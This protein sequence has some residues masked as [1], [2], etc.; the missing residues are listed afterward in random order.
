MWFKKF[1]D[2]AISLPVGHQYR[3]LQDFC[4]E[5]WNRIN[6]MNNRYQVKL[7]LH[8]GQ[9][10]M[11]GRC[12]WKWSCTVLVTW[13]HVK[14]SLRVFTIC[15]PVWRDQTTDTC[16]Q[17]TLLRKNRAAPPCPGLHQH[18]TAAL[19]EHQSEYI[20]LNGKISAGQSSPQ[21]PD[22]AGLHTVIGGA[23]AWW[24]IDVHWS[25]ACVHIMRTFWRSSVWKATLSSWIQSAINV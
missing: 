16:T 23:W 10:N 12:S 20:N 24:W 15:R 25:L 3:G 17:L 21:P 18:H 22:D 1:G 13:L 7:I 11:N 4:S 2:S 9:G 14:W 19:L 5:M 6:K 8:H